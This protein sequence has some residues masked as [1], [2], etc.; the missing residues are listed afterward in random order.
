MFLSKGG[1]VVDPR[2]E[3]AHDLEGQRALAISRDIGGEYCE[4]HALCSRMRVHIGEGIAHVGGHENR[5]G[6]SELPGERRQ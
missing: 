5:I 4:G 2:G 1:S 6:G 3:V